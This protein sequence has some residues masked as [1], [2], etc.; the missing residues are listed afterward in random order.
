M[1][2]VVSDTSLLIH[3][4]GLGHLALLRALYQ[5]VLIPP[6]VWRE[7]VEEGAGRAGE[8]E[9]REAVR[10]GWM[11][12]RPVASGP[13]VHLLKEGLDDGEA[14]AIAPAFEAGADLVLLDETQAREKVGLMGLRLT[15]TIGVLIRA[16]RDG[17]V[18]TLRPL[19]DQLRQESFSI[20]ES[21]YWRAL[22][23]DPVQP[24]IG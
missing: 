20:S 16:K 9:V 8:A 11:E 13:L 22:N 15:G 18:E 17:M 19:L 12:V 2:V 21:L 10:S 1:A 5:Q 23:Q 4:S 24:Y 3:L 6:A 7:T 14:E